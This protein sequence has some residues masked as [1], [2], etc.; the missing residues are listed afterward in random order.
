ML[1]VLSEWL[2]E[3]ADSSAARSHAYRSKQERER[4]SKVARG[5]TADVANLTKEDQRANAS[6]TTSYEN[7]VERTAGWFVRSHLWQL[8]TVV[9]ALIAAAFGAGI[10]AQRT[11]PN[12]TLGPS[13]AVT[14]SPL[15]V[16]GARATTLPF[17]L[18]VRLQFRNAPSS[19]LMGVALAPSPGRTTPQIQSLSVSKID[20]VESD[21][22]SVFTVVTG[23]LQ[24]AEPLPE[25]GRQ[26]TGVV[27]VV[28][29]TKSARWGDVRT[30]TQLRF[31]PVDCGSVR[32]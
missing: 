21:S 31:L 20:E 7:Q 13:M 28:L 19:G 22:V 32:R 1:E 24:T 4:L 29:V 25:C 16:I 5:E 9:G 3:V 11:F 2:A 14:L 15:E 6:E 26:V 8:L 18:R 17:T 12:G 10:W 30:E 27:D 23:T